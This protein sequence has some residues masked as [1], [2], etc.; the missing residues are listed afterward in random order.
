MV[1]PKGD[2]SRCLSGGFY[3]TTLRSRVLPHGGTENIVD[4]GGRCG[5]FPCLCLE[6]DSS[7]YGQD[8]L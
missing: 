6:R 1:L 3:Q 2:G 5:F 4:K 8:L 7:R